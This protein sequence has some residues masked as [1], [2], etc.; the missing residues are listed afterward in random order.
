MAQ[1]GEWNRHQHDFTCQDM[2]KYEEFVGKPLMIGEESCNKGGG[3]NG[4]YEIIGS[5]GHELNLRGYKSSDKKK[6]TAPNDDNRRKISH[7]VGQRPPT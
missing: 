2:E 4:Q 3:H 5:R 6:K 1:A 7:P